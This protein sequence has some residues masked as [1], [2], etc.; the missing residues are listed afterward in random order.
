MRNAECRVFLLQI[1]IR[2]PEHSTPASR[3]FIIPGMNELT[4]VGGKGSSSLVR[5]AG[6]L[7]MSAVIIG[8]A[9]FLGSC[10]GYEGCLKL[11]FL[12]VVLGVPGIVLSILG[13]AFQKNPEDTHVL[14]ALFPCVL[15]LIGGLVE[16]SAWLHWVVF[17]KV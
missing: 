10:A 14:G 5:V 13:G 8:L 12:P 11:S 2:N 9:I 16:M 4:S 6:G 3:S 7:G 1:E 17:Y 15:G